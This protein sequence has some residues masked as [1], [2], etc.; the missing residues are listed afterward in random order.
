MLYNLPLV[1]LNDELCNAM[2]A[3]V[4]TVHMY[5]CDPEIISLHVVA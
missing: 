4:H 1:E 3:V 2:I 5:V